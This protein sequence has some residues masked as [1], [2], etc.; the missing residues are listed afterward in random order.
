MILNVWLIGEVL[1]VKTDSTLLI[2]YNGYYMQFAKFIEQAPEFFSVVL[3]HVISG[4]QLTSQPVA[5]TSEE[6]TVTDYLLSNSLNSFIF[7]S[8]MNKC[9]SS[10][11]I[12]VKIVSFY[13]F[14]QDSYLKVL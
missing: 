5:F 11:R 10:V 4:H 2:I 3:T 12:S 13:I 7:N 8:Q 6:Q 14:Y 1:G 9:I